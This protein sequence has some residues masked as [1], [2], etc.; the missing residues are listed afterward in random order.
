MTLRSERGEYIT[1]KLDELYPEI[2]IPVD[3]TDA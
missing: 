2:P 1:R 3:H